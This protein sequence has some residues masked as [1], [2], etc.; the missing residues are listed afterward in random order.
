MHEL[1]ATV[2][3]YDP[4]AVVTA[5]RVHPELDFVETAADTLSGADLVLVLTEWTEF[6]EL[7]ATTVASLVSSPVVID[8]RN[9]LDRDAWTAAGFTYRGMGR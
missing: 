7:D 2:S 4:E 6:R 8:G 5:R 9:C 1:G 3:A